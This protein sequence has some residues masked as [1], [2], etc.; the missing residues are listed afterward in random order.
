MGLD[1]YVLF[2]DNTNTGRQALNIMAGWLDK[3]LPK[4]LQ[5]KE[6]HVQAL[7][8]ELKAELLAKPVAIVFGVAT[9]GGPKTLREYLVNH[10]GFEDRLIRCTANREFMKREQILSGSDSRFQHADRVR[11]REFLVDVAKAIFISEGKCEASAASRALGDGGAEAM[12]VFPYN[13]PTMT[14]PALWLTGVY[15]ASPWIPLV[16]RG[17]RMNP[18]T[19][20]LAGEDA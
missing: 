3:E 4:D 20:D 2:D 5:L 16:E 9:E 14:I 13:C 18:V 15:M 1:G 10:C 17:R 7:T 12:A 11:L 6:E 19:G 8:P